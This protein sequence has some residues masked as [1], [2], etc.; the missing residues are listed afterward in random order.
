[1]INSGHLETIK[2]LQ[3]A[4]NPSPAIGNKMKDPMVD[5]EGNGVRTGNCGLQIVPILLV[6]IGDHYHV[7]FQY[8]VL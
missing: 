2:V 3:L 7:Q 8:P 5:T 6:I 1:M 4:K